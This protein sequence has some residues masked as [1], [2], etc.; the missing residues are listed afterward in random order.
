MTTTLSLLG[1]MAGWLCSLAGT[2]YTDS[3][4]PVLPARRGEK[5]DNTAIIQDSESC[6]R[7]L[8]CIL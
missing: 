5:F 3:L 7:K 4:R 2:L 8:K 1:R 6:L